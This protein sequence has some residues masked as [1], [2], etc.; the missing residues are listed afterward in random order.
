MKRQQLPPQIPQP[1][2]AEAGVLL[3]LT[4]EPSPNVLLTRRA[5]HLSSH[6]GEVAFPVVNETRGRQHCSHGNKRGA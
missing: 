4:D 6:K 2:L 1:D 3:A 5:A